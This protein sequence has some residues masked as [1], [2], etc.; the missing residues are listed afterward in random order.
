MIVRD[1]NIPTDTSADDI[2][3]AVLDDKHDLEALLFFV[4][5]TVACDSGGKGTCA[6]GEVHDFGTVEDNY[7]LVFV[8]GEGWRG[9]RR[10]FGGFAFV[11][12]FTKRSFTL[13]L[14]IV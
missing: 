10:A 1:H 5:T 6:G 12:F 9:G 3:C 13:L 11:V 8:G 7:F 2:A 14:E 4:V